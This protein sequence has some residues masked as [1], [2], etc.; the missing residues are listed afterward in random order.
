MMR[1]GWSGFIAAIVM[2][3]CLLFL[4]IYLFTSEPKAEAGE[5]RTSTDLRQLLQSVGE[6]Q[7]TVR[8]QNVRISFLEELPTAKKEAAKI[9]AE[10]ARRRKEERR[11]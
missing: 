10:E 1:H 8:K 7:K 5:S 2:V 4:G 11:K 9:L 6:L 3:G